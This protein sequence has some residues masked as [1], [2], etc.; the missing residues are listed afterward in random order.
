MRGKKGA[1]PVMR[2]PAGL[3]MPGKK[4]PKGKVKKG[5]KY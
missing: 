5:K 3:P 1:K 2:M 4:M